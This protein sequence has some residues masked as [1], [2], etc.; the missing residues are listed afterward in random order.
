MEYLK[1]HWYWLVGL[2][3]GLWVFMKLVGNKASAGASVSTPT[4]SQIIYG[5]T[6][7]NDAAVQAAQINAQTQVAGAQIA[8][9]QAVQMAQF[10]V[11]QNQDTQTANVAIANVQGQYGL[12]VTNSNNN[13]A[14]HVSDNATL[15]GINAND[16]NLAAVQDSNATKLAAYGIQAQVVNTQTNAY[17]DIAQTQSNNNA[18]VSLSAI[19]AAHDIEREQ[20][21]NQE[22]LQQQTFDLERYGI[23]NKGGAGGAE[24]LAA[25]NALVNPASA[26]T[27]DMAV[28]QVATAQANST[29]G[30][31]NAIGGAV[32]GFT[33]QLVKAF[34]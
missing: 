4:G 18:S 25:W 9:G 16:T 8:A 34:G 24:Q 2:V 12:A 22:R 27:G 6:N 29:T 21:A 32:S 20:V 17:R 15:L 5:G 13:A 3:L 28:A 1:E 31:I 23:F 26:G 19:N 10:A 30:I 33:G 14:M 11:Q 7:A